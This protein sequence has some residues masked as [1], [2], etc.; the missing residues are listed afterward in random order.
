MNERGQGGS[1]QSIKGE[2]YFTVISTAASGGDLAR[3]SNITLTVQNKHTLSLTYSDKL[4]AS[5]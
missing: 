1:S 2:D 3:E 5:Q 4:K